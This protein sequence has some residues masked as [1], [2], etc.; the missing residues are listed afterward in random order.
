MG[1]TIGDP[2]GIGPE[3]SIKA[4]R[5]EKVYRECKP[6]LIGSAEAAAMAL[7][8]CGIKDL[9]INSVQ[10]PEEGSYQL[11]EIDVLDPG[12]PAAGEIN[13]GQ[14]TA[15][16]GR[17]SFS[18]VKT[19]IELA[20]A[21]RVQATVTGPINKAALNMG[22]CRY[23][24]HTE[25]YADL[26]GT[27]DYTMMLADG[28]FRVSH[29]STHVSLRQACERAKKARILKVIE[30]THEA[31]VGFGL[32][33]PRLAVAALNPHCGENGLFGTED[34]EESAPA[35]AEARARGWN[36]E[37]PIP[38]DTVFVKMLGGLYDAVI[39]MYH[40]QGHIP[41]K[42]HGFKYDDA[43]GQWNQLSGVNITLGLPIIR[44]SVDHGTAFDKAGKG[45]ANPQSML[46]AIELAAKMAA[47]RPA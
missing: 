19:A 17:A 35:V 44:T 39:A 13:L 15:E 2:A 38:A 24:G 22:G 25:I 30:L 29:V 37:G 23:A 26:T 33:A 11:G 4:L 42:L 12:L 45:T 6:L 47:N 20:L 5:R 21:G 27:R 41:A 3:V 28:G 31:L 46:E 43:S 40:D 34:D 8:Y 14:A 16:Q 18:Y 9:K 1:I 7:D 10:A 36:V 32:K